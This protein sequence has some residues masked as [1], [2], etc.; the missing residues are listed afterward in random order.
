MPPGTGGTFQRIKLA[1]GNVLRAVVRSPLQV[2]VAVLLASCLCWAYWPMFVT[3]AERW[4]HE[5]QYS[6]GYFVPLFAG[7]LLWHRRQLCPQPFQGSPRGAFLVGAGALLYLGG[8]YFHF[9]WIHAVSLLPTV[10]GAFLL[11]GGMAAVRWAWP[12]IA[13]LGFMLPLPY[14]VETSL[15]HPLQQLATE[16]SRVV[17]VLLGFQATADGNII[18]VGD[19]EILVAQACGGL[20]MC[21]TFIALA[22][23]CALVIRRPLLD[24]IVLI[25]SAI[26]IALI[27]NVIRITITG[28]LYDLVGSRAARSFYHDFAGW[29]MMALAV[30]MVWLIL[31]VLGRLLVSAESATPM[32]IAVV[33]TTPAK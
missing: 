31:K 30:G 4:A 27:A 20:S 17:L 1:G 15:A 5:P 13:F 32:P 8:T 28:V 9:P 29:F 18:T 23:G 26:P 12:A 24:R 10:F 6:H 3:I 7:F 14:Q 21:L 19:S 25:L 2:G 11:L 16:V 22:V 33:G